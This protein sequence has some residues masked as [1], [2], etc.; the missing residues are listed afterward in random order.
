MAS[1]IYEG[2]ALFSTGEQ[3]RFCVIDR[4]QKR[5]DLKKIQRKAELILK[6]L[7]VIPKESY[8]G[9]T[10]NGGMTFKEGR[11][12]EI[13][14]PVVQEMRD[15][16]GKVSIGVE[17]TPPQDLDWIDR[18]ADSGGES[19]MMNLETWDENLRQALIPGKNKYCPRDSYFKAFE[20]A[21]KVL[22]KG[23][24]STCFIIGTEPIE[25]AKKG[26][27]EVIKYGVI[28]SPLAGRYFE[29]FGDYPFTG[30]ANWREFL[31]VF[32][33]TRAAMTRQK[34]LSTDKAGCVACGM[35]DIIKDR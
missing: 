26:I 33:F 6:A 7:E 19:L 1:S 5:P 18:F 32:E 23:K 9:I 15:R 35:C 28:P 11:G 4:S 21:L 22:G 34:L 8:Q 14:I 12:L 27:A 13:L 31:N 24:V 10:L 3:C 25:S 16:L 20:R 30:Q 29:Q 17:M 2:C